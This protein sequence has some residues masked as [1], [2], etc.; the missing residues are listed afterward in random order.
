MVLRCQM[1]SGKKYRG[2]VSKLDPP[3]LGEPKCKVLHKKNHGSEMPDE[4]R[5]KVPREGFEGRSTPI[6]QA[7]M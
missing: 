7:K 6:R 4:V 2:K 1:R 5:Q 3:P